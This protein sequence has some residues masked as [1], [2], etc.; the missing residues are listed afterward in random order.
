MGMQ[1][2]GQPNQFTG[3]YG[4]Y[5]IK[6]QRIKMESVEKLIRK[7]YARRQNKGR[8]QALKKCLPLGR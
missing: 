3:D 6:K 2:L 1:Y 5:V 7:Y 8:S 4:V